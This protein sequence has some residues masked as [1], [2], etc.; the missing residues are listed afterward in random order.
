M[1]DSSASCSLTH[2]N[3]QRIRL[4]FFH[5]ISLSCSLVTYLSDFLLIRKTGKSHNLPAM[6]LPPKFAG[7]M[8]ATGGME[9]KHTLELCTYFGHE[10]LLHHP[11]PVRHPA[12]TFLTIL[13]SRSRLRLSLLCQNVHHNPL[14]RPAPHKK[15]IHKSRCADHLPSADPA[16]ASLIHTRPRNRRRC[17][18]TCTCKVLGFLETAVRSPERIF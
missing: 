17:L 7:Q 8:V 4:P 15:A 14:P 13:Q 18:E 16:L 3:I 11:F 6:A 10:L 2:E 9:V 1:R 12:P 5:C